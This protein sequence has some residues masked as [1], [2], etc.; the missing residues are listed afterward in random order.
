MNSSLLYGLPATGITSDSQAP[1]HQ[2]HSAQ[3]RS[4][5]LKHQ[6]Y[7][8]EPTDAILAKHRLLTLPQQVL[9]RTS[10]HDQAGA[11]GK[12]Q[13][14]NLEDEQDC[15]VIAQDVRPGLSESPRRV[16]FRVQQQCGARTAAAHGRVA[17]LDSSAG[18]LAWHG[19][20]SLF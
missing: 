10:S 5:L 15:V 8:R 7:S 2:V 20:L 11:D 1:L 9:D 12:S 19:T 14:N 4:V 3:V 17:S 13:D 18:M 6:H 16:C